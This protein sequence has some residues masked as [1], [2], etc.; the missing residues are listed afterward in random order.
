MFVLFII[1]EWC[2]NVGPEDDITTTTD[3]IDFTCA[4]AILGPRGCT[5]SFLDSPHI[6][7]FTNFQLDTQDV[8][9]QITKNVAEHIP[10][11]RQLNA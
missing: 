7:T 9:Q 5:L 4:V 10:G 1:I 6:F 11:P 8:S 3:L 2:V